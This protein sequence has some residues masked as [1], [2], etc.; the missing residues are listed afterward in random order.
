M[1]NSVPPSLLLTDSYRNSLV[2][3]RYLTTEAREN[4]LGSQSDVVKI[5]TPIAQAINETSCDEIQNSHVL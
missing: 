4:T 5:P 3:V 1:R 2:S